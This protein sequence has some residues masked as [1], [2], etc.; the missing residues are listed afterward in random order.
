MSQ[1]RDL[2][3]FTK[4]LLVGLLNTAFGYAVFALFYAVTGSYRVAVIPATCIGVIFN[5]VTTGR[6]VFD[7][8][9]LW[10]FVPFVAGYAAI[11]VFNILCLDAVTRTGVNALRCAVPASADP[12]CV[13]LS[14]QRSSGVYEEV[15]VKT[16]SIVTPCYNE[17]ATIRDCYEAVVEL[18]DSKLSN[19]R[20]EHIFC[21]NASEDR[22]ADI[23]REIAAA[24]KSVRVILNAR[25]FGAMRNNYNGVMA[26]SGDV[27]LLLLPADLQDPPELLPEFVA[28]WEQG[29]EIVYGIRAQREEGRIMRNVRGLYYRVLT[30]FAE[31]KVPPGVGDFQLVDRRVVEAMRQIRVSYPFMRMMTFECGGRAIGIPYTWR[32]R[33]KGLSKNRLASLVDQA[34]NGLVSFTTAPLRLGLFVGFIIASLSVTYSIVALLAGLLYS[35]SVA[36]PGIMTLIVALFFFGGVQLFFMGMLGEYVLAIFGQVRKKPM[37]FERGRIN[38]DPDESPKEDGATAS[39]P[40]DKDPRSETE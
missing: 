17:E 28:L 8:R 6:L 35:H 10:L 5:F 40:A 12:C 36:Q 19:Y 4:F 21:D 2:H 16:I 7:N 14:R 18:F 13:C 1:T 26:S 3:R 24:D 20:R 29:Y 11:A 27:V 9:R 38:F 34:I 31:V 32:A 23:L 25:N 15:A 33:K 39:R 30:R 22:T 37:V